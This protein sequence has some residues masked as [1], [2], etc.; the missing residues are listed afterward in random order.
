MKTHQLEMG[1]SLLP[2]VLLLLVIAFYFRIEPI[3]HIHHVYLYGDMVHYDHL[4]VTIMLHH[5]Y[6]Y[7][8]FQSDGFVT[9]GYPLFL[10]ACYSIANLF[11][12]NHNLQI[13][14]VFYVQGLLSTLSV[15][16][17]YLIAKRSLPKWISFCVALLF[18]VYSPSISAS[19]LLLTETL[20]VFLLL[21][22]VYSFQI[23]MEKQT[24]LYWLISGLILGFVSVVRPTTFPLAIAALVFVL[25]AKKKLWQA[26][27]AEV[28]Y[29]VGFVVVL[30]PWWIRNIVVLKR[31]LLTD[32]DSGNPLLYGTDPNFQTDNLAAGVTNQKAKAIALIKDHFMHQPGPTIKWYTIGKLNDLFDEQWYK[33][34]PNWLSHIW[35]HLHLPMILIGAAGVLVALFMRKMR[36]VGILAIFLVV[37]QLP[38][39]PVNRYAY[40]VIPFLF[41]GVGYVVYLLTRLVRVKRAAA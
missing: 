31:V 27:W 30:L 40:P 19:Q 18:A 12:G 32:D 11:T 41:I 4:A 38:F 3:R 9:P 25:F 5:V 15:G 33:I 20:Y 39:I 17:L 13:L 2:L 36:F 1:M 6:S 10:V 7:W 8:G 26:I 21:A 29:G 28:I 37:V 14:V 35:N 24:W 16:L 23:A 34:Q 22:F